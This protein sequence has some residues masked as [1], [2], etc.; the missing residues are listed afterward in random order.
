MEI[1]RIITELFTST[2]GC[3]LQRWRKLSVLS[4]KKPAAPKSIKSARLVRN[5]TASPTMK[6][7]AISVKR[8]IAVRST[9]SRKLPADVAKT[10]PAGKIANAVRTANVAR[11]PV[12]AAVKLAPVRKVANAV[13]TA[14]VVRPSANVAA[15]TV[16]V[17]KAANAVR[18]ANAARTL[19]VAA[20]TALVRKAA[21]AVRTAN[22]V[23]TPVNAAVRAA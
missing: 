11:T 8:M 6:T 14:N 12:N 22:A 5:T 13:R 3:P 7:G 1:G 2:T 21:N 4:A 20:K 17:R 15:K 16:P 18:T 10:A 9:L 23:K 19:A